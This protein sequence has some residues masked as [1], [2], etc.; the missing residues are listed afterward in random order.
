M[1]AGIPLRSGL[2]ARNP[3]KDAI[4]T[5]IERLFDGSQ[6]TLCPWFRSPRQSLG[7]QW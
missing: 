1:A 5:Q 6:L 4:T 3:A 2:A 7:S